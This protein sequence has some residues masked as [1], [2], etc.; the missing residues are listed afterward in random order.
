MVASMQLYFWATNDSS[1]KFTVTLT[2]NANLA[3]HWISAT[4][5]FLDL[6]FVS[7]ALLLNYFLKIFE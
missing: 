6:Y 2:E 1:L 3:L 5:V 4:K 7:L